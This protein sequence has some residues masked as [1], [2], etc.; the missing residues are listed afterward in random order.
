MGRR[1]GHVRVAVPDLG[2]R[3]DPAYRDQGRRQRQRRTQRGWCRWGRSR[4][5]RRRPGSS[6]GGS[7]DRS[8]WRRSRP[9]GDGV[10]RRPQARATSRPQANRVRPRA[11]HGSAGSSAQPRWPITPT[12][13]I[14]PRRSAS[15]AARHSRGQSAGDAPSRAIPASR[16]RWTRARPGAAATAAR[17]SS[18]GTARSIRRAT[19]VAKS[20]STGFSQ[21]R[22]GASSP[23]SRSGHA[24]GSD[25]TPS[26]RAPCAER[27][28]RDVDGAV[29]E[30]VGLHDRHQLAGGAAGDQRGVR[31]HRRQ[32]DGEQRARARRRPERP[33]RR[34]SCRGR[35]RDRPVRRVRG[36]GDQRPVAVPEAPVPPLGRVVDQALGGQHPAQQ[37]AVGPGVRADAVRGEPAPPVALLGRRVD[38]GAEVELVAADVDQGE[39]DGGARRREVPRRAATRSGWSAARARLPRHRGARPAPA[40]AYDVM[41][42]RWA[43]TVR[44]PSTTRSRTPAGRARS[45]AISR[46]ASPER[47]RAPLRVTWHGAGGPPARRTPAPGRRARAGRTAGSSW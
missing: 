3:A 22:S 2:A 10:G 7:A 1:V 21:L 35:F 37:L 4:P 26:A 43:S 19:A 33:P 20:A 39:V 32:V 44:W 31:R 23:A 38:R 47:T 6:C 30:A 15:R 34:R 36:A 29:A 46:S 28:P 40:A 18:P 8:G 25:V 5:V 11:L 16:C 27:R 12:T 42:A 17:C 14:W 9:G 24:S 13:S 45:A 41:I